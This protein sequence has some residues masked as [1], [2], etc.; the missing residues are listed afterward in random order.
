MSRAAIW[1]PMTKP[2]HTMKPC[3]QQKAAIAL[4]ATGDLSPEAS[5]TLGLHL[6]KCEGCRSYANELSRICATHRSALDLQPPAV[7][8]DDGF[9]RRLQ[10]RIEFERTRVWSM[11]LGLGV[12]L[13]Q[14]LR[15]GV[16]VGLACVL[17]FFL[18]SQRAPGPRPHPARSSPGNSN[19]HRLQSRP[20]WTL[21]LPMTH[22]WR[23]T[24]RR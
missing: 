1:S 23:P 21:R 11:D 6:E 5:S 4:R 2:V 17:V 8:A 18:V 10:Q 16:A 22:V 7:H 12:I 20:R 14:L 19:R 9:H 15:P 3:K 24:L 13:R